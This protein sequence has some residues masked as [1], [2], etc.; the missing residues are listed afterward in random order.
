MHLLQRDILHT[1]RFFHHKGGQAKC[2]GNNCKGKV[3][4]DLTRIQDPVLECPGNEIPS[5]LESV[6]RVHHYLGSEG[7]RDEKSERYKDLSIMP[8]TELTHWLVPFIESVDKKP[9]VRLL[10]GA[11]EVEFWRKKRIAAKA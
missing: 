6:L 5:S 1:L 3:L 4:L 10:D 2:T 11:G 8:E 7:N 9:A